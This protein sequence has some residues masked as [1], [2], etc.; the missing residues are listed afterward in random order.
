[1]PI[2]RFGTDGWNARLDEDFTGDNVRRV[3]DAIGSVFADEFP[4][5][6]IYVGY[7]T[8]AHAREMA[9]LA[10][11]ALAGKGLVAKLSDVACPIPA[12]GWAVANDDDA[13]GGVMLS[14]SHHSQDYEGIR[15]R[16]DDGSIAPAEFLRLVEGAVPAQPAPEMGDVEQADLMGPYLEALRDQVDTDVIRAAKLHVVVDPL[17]GAGSGHLAGLLRSMGCEVDEIHVADGSGGFHGMDPDATEPWLDGCEQAVA[18]SSAVAGFALDGDGDR[19]AAIDENGIFLTPHRLEPL[20]MEHLVRDRGLDGRFVLTLSDSA[21]TRRL[22]ASLGK[23]V[24]ITP[25]GFRGIHDVMLKGDV[26]C[27][28]E[29]Y[30]GMSIPSFLMERDGLLVTLLLVEMVAQSGKSLSELVLGLEAEIGKMEYARRDIRIDAGMIQ[31]FRN[32]LPGINPP[33]L[34]GM[35]PVY[36]SHA[37]GLYLRFGDDSWVLLR[38][39]RLDPVVRVYAEAPTA[40]QRDALME[41]AC[42]LARSGGL[43]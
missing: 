1:M 9:E 10:A 35:A 37:D 40:E 28:M 14:A 8:R 12:L 3:A 21:M 43:I 22:A 38:P 41:D 6:T 13:C 24:Q 23:E 4:H 29:E 34:A 19:S 32:M 36:V 5:A 26:I 2:I 11:G 7:D 27:A 18:S 20:V 39:S 33:E 25:I 30:G 17:Y 16:M 42:E 15:I 31:A